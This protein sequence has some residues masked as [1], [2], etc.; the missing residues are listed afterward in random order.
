MRRLLVIAML[1]MPLDAYAW[2]D[3]MDTTCR[4]LERLEKE[5]ERERQEERQREDK[6]QR[7][8]LEDSIDRIRKTPAR[9]R[10]NP[11]NC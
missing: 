5:E 4:R 2:C 9:C 8:D 1:I 11:D 10:L 6:R 7:E 3:I